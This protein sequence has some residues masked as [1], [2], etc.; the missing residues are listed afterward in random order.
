MRIGRVLH[1]SVLLLEVA[2]LT[3]PVKCATGLAA[4]ISR[5]RFLSIQAH[6]NMVDWAKRL[7]VGPK[8]LVCHRE[9]LS[10]DRGGTRQSIFVC[11]ILS[12]ATWTFYPSHVAIRQVTVPDPRLP[13][14]VRTFPSF[15]L[16]R[17]RWLLGRWRGQIN[18]GNV[19]PVIGRRAITLPTIYDP[20][21]HAFYRPR[22][23]RN[24]RRRTARFHRSRINTRCRQFRR[25]I[26]RAFPMLHTF[27][28][29]FRTTSWMLR[30]YA[31]EIQQLR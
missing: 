27:G 1:D 8:R 15:A 3:A 18:R 26:L 13:F 28:A 10:R 4:N 17:K 30:H 22:K 24:Q 9:R 7:E 2:L 11:Q 19:N 29:N 31:T 25:S 23:N 16:H 12:T 20:F 6:W 5:I 14:A 21:R